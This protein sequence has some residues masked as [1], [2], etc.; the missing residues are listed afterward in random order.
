VLTAASVVE[1][2]ALITRHTALLPDDAWPS[3]LRRLLER[4]MAWSPPPWPAPRRTLCRTDANWRNLLR[5]P[6][7]WASVDWEN[8]GWGDP[9]FEIA[10]LMTHPAYDVVPPSRWAWVIA[11]YVACVEDP[12][13][14]RRIRAYEVVM[15][16]WWAVRWARTLYEVPRGLDQRLVERGPSWQ[17]EAE[18]AFTRALARAEKSLDAAQR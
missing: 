2:Q 18:H 13:V 14:E 16:V 4:F 1:G 12:L 11:A 17:G 7:L 5:C 15:Q 9:A 8:S 6:T 10:E 3:A